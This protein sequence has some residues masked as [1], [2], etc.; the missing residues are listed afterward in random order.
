MITMES[1]EAKKYIKAGEILGKLQKKARKDAVSGKKLLDIALNVEKGVKDLSDGKAELAF[2]VNLS[3]NEA[4]AH[5]TPSEGDETVLEDK[6]L[7]KIDI[8]VQVDGFIADA[9]FSVNP[10]NDWAAL[11][12]ASELALEN[13]LSMAKPDVEIGKIG[14][15][16]EKTIKSKGFNPVQNLTGHGLAQYETHV[17][18]SLANIANNDDR[19]LEE[20]YAYA[21]EPFATNGEGVVRESP[22]SEIFAIAEP[23]QV[24]NTYARQ[25]QAFILEKYKTLPFAERW[26]WENI[27]MNELQQKIAL[28]ELLKAKCIKAFPVLR[29]Q[30]GKFVSQAE[31]TILLYDG[32]AIRL[33]K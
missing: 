14:A 31:N 28:R 11:I 3:L 15:E 26:I 18:P 25:V 21:F 2:P 13:A 9:S 10:N 20:G 29:E 1:E 30:E 19:V 24:R 27:K 32:K 8:G 16:I 23:K 12:E 6:D 7:I 22:Q 33:V 4:A 17:A 5:Y